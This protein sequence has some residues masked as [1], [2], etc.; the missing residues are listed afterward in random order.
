MNGVVTA[1]STVFPPIV[2]SETFYVS[3]FSELGH[4]VPV[5]LVSFSKPSANV[6]SIQFIYSHFNINSSSYN[7]DIF[8]L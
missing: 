6:T 2:P 1:F 3:A 7:K 8:L 5:Y 4:V